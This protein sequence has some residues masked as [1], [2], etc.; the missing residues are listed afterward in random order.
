MITDLGLICAEPIRG[1]LRTALVAKR[2][3]G[4]GELLVREKPLIR[5]TLTKP[6]QVGE[7]TY[8][9]DFAVDLVVQIFCFLAL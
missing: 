2:G 5:A 7:G 4:P 8:D 1:S 3:C 9:V 6:T